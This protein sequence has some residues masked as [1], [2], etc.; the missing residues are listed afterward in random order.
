MTEEENK[1]AKPSTEADNALKLTA[2]KAAVASGFLSGFTSAANQ[3]SLQLL[4]RK[5]SQEEIES[6]SQ[7]ALDGA[8][9][10]YV[11]TFLK[12]PEGQVIAEVLDVEI[13]EVQEEET[14]NGEDEG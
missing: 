6:Y 1:E 7:R 2:L 5:L 10:W 8:D 14:S 13:A 12:S 9:N 11:P 4:G 3:V